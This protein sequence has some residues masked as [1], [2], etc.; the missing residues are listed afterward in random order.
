ME[1]KNM[2]LSHLLLHILPLKIGAINQKL[3]KTM[4]QHVGI[5]CGKTDAPEAEQRK[6]GTICDSSNLILNS[7]H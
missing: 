3:K 4:Y 2:K 7:R 6:V 1:H 5:T